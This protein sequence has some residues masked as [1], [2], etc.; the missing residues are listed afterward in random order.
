MPMYLHLSQP[1]H[2]LCD[3]KSGINSLSDVSMRPRCHDSDWLD[4]CEEAL[5]NEHLHQMVWDLYHS[6]YER[7]PNC[8][9]KVQLSE[10]EWAICEPKVERCRRIKDKWGQIMQDF[11]AHRTRDRIRY[12]IEEEQLLNDETLKDDSVVI[13]LKEERRKAMLLQTKL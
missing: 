9:L 11:E 10:E 7:S 8:S 5:A 4:D 3:F 1:S 6:I 2:R 12:M 13:K